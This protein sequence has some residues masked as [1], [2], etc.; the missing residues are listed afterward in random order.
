MKSVFVT[1]SAQCTRSEQQAKHLGASLLKITPLKKTRTRLNALLRYPL[2]FSQTLWELQKLS[3]EVIFAE[4]QPPPLLLAVLIHHL[5]HKTPFVLDSH[6]GPFNDPR[7]KW[8]FPYYRWMTQKAALNL[9][10]NR[11]HQGLIEDW[12]GK[13]AKISDI[14]VDHEF[15]I[16]KEDYSRPTIAVVMSYSF[17]EPVEEVFT[18]AR[19][20]PEVHFRV[21]GNPKKLSPHLINNLPANIEL[22]G[23]LSHQDYWSLLASANAVMVLTKEDHTMQKGAYEALSLAQPIITSDWEPLRDSFGP[24]AAFVDNSPESIKAAVVKILENHDNYLEA[25]HRQ[26]DLRRRYYFE[27][28]SKVLIYLENYLGGTTG[29]EFPEV[30]TEEV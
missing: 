26:R 29:R 4:N 7:W 2:S 28:V 16:I 25:A 17:D 27:T 8:A 1:W 30:L 3:P 13:T 23:F 11:Y 24:A 5:F 14:P 6:T 10:T 19:Q 21:T 22:T 12:G 20:L 18:A 15:D 9:N